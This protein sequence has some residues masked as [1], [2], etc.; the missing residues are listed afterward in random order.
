MWLSIKSLT[1]KYKDRYIFD[2]TSIDI[3]DNNIFLKGKNGIGKTSLLE[4]IYKYNSY[5]GEIYLYNQNLK[6]IAKKELTTDISYIKQFALF[7]EDFSVKE[8]LRILNVDKKKYNFYVNKFKVKDFFNKKVK[9]LSGGEKQVLNL[10]IGFSK[11]KKILLIDEPLNNLSQK[12]K[13]ILIELLKSDKRNKII[14]SHEDIDLKAK[15]INIK[16]RG[17]YYE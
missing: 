16:N 13:K 6:N 9:E 1:L 2:K 4:L 17:L 12:N 5:Y 7:F 8:N 3:Y 15:F 10:C 14:I 11:G